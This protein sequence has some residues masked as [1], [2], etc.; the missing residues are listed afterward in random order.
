MTIDEE[1]EE[2]E[3]GGEKR[4]RRRTRRRR[5]ALLSFGRSALLALL[6]HALHCAN[7][8]AHLLTQ[9]RA[10]GNVND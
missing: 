10:H 2:E 7:L 9:P 4:G 6:V 1:E 8:F 3:K 5:R